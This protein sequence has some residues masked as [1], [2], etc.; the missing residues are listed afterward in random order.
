MTNTRAKRARRPMAHQFRASPALIAAVREFWDLASPWRPNR[1]AADALLISIFNR[2]PQIGVALRPILP[3]FD[4][5]RKA[6]PLPYNRRVLSY[7]NGL[8]RFPWVPIDRK[9]SG[10]VLAKLTVPLTAGH[11]GCADETPPTILVV[12]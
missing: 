12:R 8:P 11:T 9:I 2:H 1:A 10:E 7:W 5:P 6:E 4:F 3:P